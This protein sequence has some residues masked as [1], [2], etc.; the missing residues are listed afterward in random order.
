M[1]FSKDFLWGG[2]ISAN[3]AEGGFEDRG[4]DKDDFVPV[5]PDRKLVAFGQ[6]VIGP[7]DTEHYF[8]SRFGID[9]Y[10]HY[11]EDIKLLGEMGFKCFRLSILWA[12]I[13]PNGD[14]AQPSEKG[15]AFYEDVFRECHKYGIEPL[16]TLT[17]FDCPM[18]LIKKYGGWRSREMVSLYRRY[19]QT[20]VTRYKGLV[21]YWLTFNEINMAMMFP[22]TGVGP[23][24]NV[25][26]VKY[27]S[28]HHQMLSAAEAIKIV[29]ETDPDNKIGC[30]MMSAQAYGYS[31]APEDQWKIVERDHRN[32]A[33]ID[34]QTR[35]YYPGYLLKQ[36]ER[37][38]ANLVIS[39]EDAA[40]LRENT[41]DF[42]S[43]SYYNT[44]CESADPET[45]KKIASGNGQKGV[46]NPYL[47]ENEWGW[48]I[49]PT[50]FRI[51]LNKMYERYQKPLFVVEN[52]LGAMDHVKADGTIE[53][54]YRIGY[55]REHIQ[56]LRA[57][58]DVDGVDVMGYLV[59]GCIDL[60]SA[61]GGEMKKRYGMVYVDLDDLGHGTMARSKKKSFDWYKKV[62]A[63]NGEDLD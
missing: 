21:K 14:D 23:D 61:S 32:F 3:Q 17:H 58:I 34:I 16:V 11:K 27:D 26:Q 60:V 20:V 1:A 49:D 29:H 7:D 38:G 19:C 52:G 53:D 10:H 8:P 40:L 22:P 4:L 31:C 56:A 5:G 48:A 41:V 44:T 63:T 13:F 18:N 6:K 45:M 54:D 39:P 50:G 35:G 57:A 51:L 47:K 43:F 25:N 2:A 62:I 59:W 28:I 30:M 42:V 33:L 12:R 36:I 37:E 15:L 24:E 9:F 55:L 46:R